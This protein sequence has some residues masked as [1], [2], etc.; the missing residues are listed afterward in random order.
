MSLFDKSKPALQAPASQSVTLNAKPA[1]PEVYASHR[2]GSEE[3]AIYKLV[4]DGDLAKLTPNQRIQ[5][6]KQ[7]CDGMGLNAL[8]KPFAF[9][10]F[11]G[12]ILLYALKEASTQLAKRDCVSV[13]I[14]GELKHIADANILECHVRATS[15]SY[16]AG[17]YTLRITDDYA[18]LPYGALKGETAA[19]ARMK[20]ITKAK[21][22]AILAHCGL[23]MLDEAELE[24]ISGK[25]QRLS[26]EEAT[27]IDVKPEQKEIE[28]VQEAEPVDNN[29]YPEFF[30]A[31]NIEVLDDAD[32]G[33]SNHFEFTRDTQWLLRKIK[34][35]FSELDRSAVVQLAETFRAAQTKTGILD[36]L[37]EKR[38]YM[39]ASAVQSEAAGFKTKAQR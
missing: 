5:Y 28:K 35:F 14:K 11:D 32:P 10:K 3:D 6:Y 23:G 36:I 25:V 20:L 34:E 16:F 12:K 30:V 33:E 7:M 29:V 21:R 31:R 9:V 24:T 38:K 2:A 1:Q 13:E 18:A 8:A 15:P 37:A 26:Y 39:S 22:R 27:S 17:Q 4:T 19:N